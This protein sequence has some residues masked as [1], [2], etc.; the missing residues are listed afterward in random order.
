MAYSKAKLKAVEI[1]HLLVSDH[2]G[3]EYYQTDV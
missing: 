1:K 3:Y 2:S